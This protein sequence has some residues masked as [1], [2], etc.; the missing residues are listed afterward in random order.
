MFIPNLINRKRANAPIILGTTIPLKVDESGFGVWYWNDLPVSKNNIQAT[1]TVI[2]SS[3]SGL[4]AS[5]EYGNDQITTFANENRIYFKL[6]PIDP[7]SAV[8]ETYSG[9]NSV[10]DG[11]KR[12]EIYKKKRYGK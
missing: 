2:G 10:D 3:T 5:Q 1:S 6:D 4:K 11:N 8:F 12:S 9:W 7:T